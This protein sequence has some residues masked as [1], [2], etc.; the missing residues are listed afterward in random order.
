MEVV[1]FVVCVDWLVVYV[2]IE[3]LVVDIDILFVELFGLNFVDGVFGSFSVVSLVF[4]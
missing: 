3:V 4:G 1:Y 2:I